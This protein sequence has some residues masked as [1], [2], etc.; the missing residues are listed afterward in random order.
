MNPSVSDFSSEDA[1]KACVSWFDKPWVTELLEYTLRGGLSASSSLS[2]RIF[3]VLTWVSRCG[4]SKFVN[5]HEVTANLSHCSVEKWSIP[6]G[7]VEIHRLQKTIL[8]SVGSRTSNTRATRVIGVAC[9]E[10][11]G[12]HVLSCFQIG[13]VVQWM[14]ECVNYGSARIFYVSEYH[15]FVTCRH[16]ILSFIKI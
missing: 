6:S 9:Q 15:N 16:H 4:S 10:N 13:T 11:S 7:L 3:V 14:N 8:R 5:E 2:W 1:K 12:G